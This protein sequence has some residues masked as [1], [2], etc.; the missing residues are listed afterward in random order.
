M[1]ENQTSPKPSE[2]QKF[3]HVVLKILSVSHEELQKRR[4]CEVTNTTGQAVAL[5]CFPSSATLP[6][7]GGSL[8]HALSQRRP[9]L[10]P[11]FA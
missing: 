11:S 2:A 3:R 9:T 8:G 6:D 10:Q 4:S 7:D 1:A 5:N